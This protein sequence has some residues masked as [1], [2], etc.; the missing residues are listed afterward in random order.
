[1]RSQFVSI[2]FGCSLVFQTSLTNAFISRTESKRLS[3][4]NCIVNGFNFEES[5][6]KIQKLIELPLLN[7]VLTID[8][9]FKSI[10]SFLKVLPALSFINSIPEFTAT[11]GP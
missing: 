8:V 11:L 7:Q 5:G 9:K 4:N 1:M 2:I 3:I 10:I 6:N